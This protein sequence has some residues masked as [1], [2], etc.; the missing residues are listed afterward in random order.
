[1]KLVMKDEH[2]MI[3]LICGIQ[4]KDSSEIM[5]RREKDSQTLQKNLWL[6][7]GWGGRDELGVWDWHIHVVVYE[8]TGQQE[9]AV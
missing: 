8:T 3:S 5:Y 9:P 7:K 6:P 2:H 1:M 4:K